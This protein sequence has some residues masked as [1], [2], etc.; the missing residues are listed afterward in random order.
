MA[1][2]LEGTAYTVA[3]KVLINKTF[4]QMFASGAEGQC[5]FFVM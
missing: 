5:T 3:I 2:G 1:F 4:S